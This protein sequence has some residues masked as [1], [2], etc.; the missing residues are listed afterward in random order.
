MGGG[1]WVH[2]ILS[3]FTNGPHWK[4]YSAREIRTYFNLLSPDFQ[5]RRLQY[6]SIPYFPTN[7]FEKKLWRVAERH[8]RILRRNIF[9]ELG[10]PTKEHGITMVPSW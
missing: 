4:L 7:T 1:I 8:I 5:V 6:V 9:A 10:L 3:K 2:E